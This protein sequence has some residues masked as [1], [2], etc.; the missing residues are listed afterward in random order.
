MDSSPQ[1]LFIY[2]FS[3]FSVGHGRTRGSG[4]GG[5]GGGGGYGGKEVVSGFSKITARLTELFAFQFIWGKV[6]FAGVNISFL[7]TVQNRLWLPIIFAWT[8]TKE[9]TSTNYSK[10]ILFIG[11]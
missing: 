10:Y 9:K 2:L 4:G 7:K 8:K 5:G 3:V 11:I 1:C 6:G